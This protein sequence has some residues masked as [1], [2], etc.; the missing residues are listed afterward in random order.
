MKYLPCLL[1]I[2][3]ALLKLFLML[4]GLIVVPLG[5]WTRHLSL[6]A[7]EEERS[8]HWPD[9]FWLW[10]NDEEGVPDWWY[11]KAKEKWWTRMFPAF[12]WLAIRN[13]VN[14]LRFAFHDPI[15][16]NI[17]TNAP[18]GV[19][20][21]QLIKQGLLVGWRYMWKGPYSSYRR[22]WLSKKVT[23]SGSIAM[24]YSE[25]YL[26]WKLGSSVPGNGFTM[27]VRLKRGIG[28]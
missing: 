14:N 22:V 1:W 17:D 9:I 21:H 2:P 3:M 27:Q 12:W 15:L 6:T 16:P 25:I 23:D 19:E 28:T 13:P 18:G 10:W 20:A 26:G 11:E 4:A 24:V 8:K 5:L 7:T